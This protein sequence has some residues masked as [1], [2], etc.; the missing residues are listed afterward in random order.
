MLWYVVKDRVRVW[1]GPRSNATKIHACA[2]EEA[3]VRREKLALG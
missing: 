2:L 3:A 1:V